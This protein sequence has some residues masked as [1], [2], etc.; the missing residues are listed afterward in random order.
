VAIFPLFKKKKLLSHSDEELIVNAIR[1]AEKFTSGE[2][3]VFIESKCRFVNPVDRAIEVF[4]GLKMEKTDDHN[5]VLVYV[6]LKDRQLAI[7]GDEGIHK[8]VG[9]QYWKNAVQQM[10]Q[11]FNKQNHVEGICE[12][13][14]TVGQT[15]A[16]EFPYEAADDKNE[17]PDEIVF[18][19]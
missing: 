17:L 12:V 13:V 3:R 14:T 1:A 4:F 5:G 11:H 18:G 9:E 10:L 19:K 16:K 8:R 6:A 15:L 7:Y 2:V